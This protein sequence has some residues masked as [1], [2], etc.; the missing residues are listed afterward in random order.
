MREFFGMSLS[1]LPYPFMIFV[2]AAIVGVALVVLRDHLRKIK[3]LPERKPHPSVPLD[4][5]YND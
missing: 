3:K 4:E 1:T 2:A 5:I